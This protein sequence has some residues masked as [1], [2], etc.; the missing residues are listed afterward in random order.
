VATD[1][2]SLLGDG[3]TV[4]ED[5]APAVERYNKEQLIAVKLPGGSQKV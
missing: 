3:A 4:V 1:V 5:L 2:K